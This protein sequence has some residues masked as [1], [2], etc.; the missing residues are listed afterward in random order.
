MDKEQFTM[1]EK[2]YTNGFRFSLSDEVKLDML[3]YLIEHLIYEPDKC[4]NDL[5]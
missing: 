3:D 1:L 4:F 5:K 2:T